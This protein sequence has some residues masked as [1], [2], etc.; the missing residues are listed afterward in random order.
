MISSLTGF[1][2]RVGI[3]IRA[4][5]LVAVMLAS[6]RAQE[7]ATTNAPP[8]AA[9]PVQP[10]V[11]ARTARKVLSQ[12][13][14]QFD[15]CVFNTREFPPGSVEPEIAQSVLGPIQVATTFYNEK[16]EEVKEADTPGRYGAVVHL[17]LGD[18]TKL[19]RF[20]TLYRIPEGA[21]T[22]PV[23]VGKFK[24]PI[25]TGTSPEIMQRQQ[26]EVG[27]A[28]KS[29]ISGDASSAG[30]GLL[31]GLVKAVPGTTPDQLFSTLMTCRSSDDAWWFELRK[32][33]GLAETYH[34]YPQL[35][36]GYDAD[37]AKRWPLIL[38][39]HGS[40]DRGTDVTSSVI[41]HGGLPKVIAGGR[42]IP[43][44]VISPRCPDEW[45]SAPVLG[46]LLDDISAKYRVDPDRIIVT[47]LSMGGFGTWELA[48]KFPDRFA[49][50]A[51][52]CGGGNPT[53]A[54]KL[55]KLPIWTFHGLL[56]TTVPE[57]LTQNMVDA[58]Q[59]AGGTPHLTIYPTVKH[60]A[61]TPAY[62]TDAL[63]TWM[64]AQ[65]R[66]K[67]EVKTPGLQEP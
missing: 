60:E 23:E 31:L 3:V 6:V 17:T 21:V 34:Y 62:D 51:P 58:I 37:P 24:I 39:L 16:F 2:F 32:R 56:D 9:A 63:Y 57:F 41:F 35:P 27:I 30:F 1:G 40:G 53:E 64:L 13:S 43:A 52:V 11:D 26:A 42:K 28:M 29:A 5:I 22:Q 19:D 61:W 18:G 8:T 66:G 48:E 54:A 36:D 55:S 20:I 46:Q 38:F 44:I 25:E 15:P 12:L 33:I 45:W 67:P 7:A 50:I 47:G 65:Q 59:K 49:A 14:Y 4:L 10:P